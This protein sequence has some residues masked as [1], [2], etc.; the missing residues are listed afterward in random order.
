MNEHR[1]K[2][3]FSSHRNPLT[4]P[5]EYERFANSFIPR[6][7]Q[8]SFL[9]SVSE[10]RESIQ[11]AQFAQ[12]RKVANSLF[13]QGKS[14]LEPHQKALSKTQQAAKE[15]FLLSYQ[16]L[17]EDKQEF[18]LAGLNK[19]LGMVAV[20]QSKLV[21]LAISQDKNP[22]KDEELRQNMVRLLT[23]IN[24][25]TINWVFELACIPT[26]AQYLMPRTLS[27]PAFQKAA[28]DA[29]FPPTRCVEVALM[30]A[31]CKTGRFIKFTPEE[32]GVMAYG[33]TLWANSDGAEAI[34]HFQGA[35]R[36]KK[37]KSESVEIKLTDTLSGWIDVW[38]PC[39]KHCEIYQYEMLAI[40]AAGGR[41]TS[42]T[43]PRSEWEEAR[44]SFR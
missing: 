20:P 8:K 35:E 28:P 21:I 33:G 17:T 14:A 30:V 11:R 12:T 15:F 9:G 13:A 24:S 34:P 2:F 5:L 41:A 1:F 22:V 32:T 37:Y 44:R 43:E 18:P 27:T 31:L 6:L 3:R 19:C 7:K 4:V 26:K 40:G 39:D 29:V 25:R 36:N 42:F 10:E 38:R 16:F 23:Q